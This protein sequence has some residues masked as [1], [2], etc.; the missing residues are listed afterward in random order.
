MFI[1]DSH[2]H[3]DYPPLS[4]N[5]TGVLERAWDVNVKLMLTIST[6]VKE[7]QKLK[8]IIEKNDNVYGSVGT[9]PHN[10][11]EELDVTAQ[12][13]IDM[14]KHP[15]VVAI[16]EVGLDYYYDNAPR[17]AQA[18]GFRTHIEA[19]RQTGL[20]LVIHS[21]D[22]ETDTI[23]IL[24]EEM[25]KGSFKPLLHCFSSK[26]ELAMRGLELGA[27]ISVSGIITYKNA[28][29]IRE[30]IKDVP[31]D[32]LLVETDAPY[33]APTPHRGKKNEP[34]FVVHTLEKLA[35]IKGVSKEHMAQQ[36]SENF[37]QLFSKVKAPETFT[38][39]A[40]E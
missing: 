37:F 5:V 31:L 28:E 3:L 36:T 19:A 12:D 9:H 20:P 27:Y 6:R 34:S 23:A 2:C 17:Q 39:S 18:Q 7:F 40:A 26:R 25:A 29:D 4:E 14:A 16:G 22:A 24:E 30:T 11:D 8:N 35:E 38:K 1:I 21:R 10:A 32:R 33:L 15:K 13:L